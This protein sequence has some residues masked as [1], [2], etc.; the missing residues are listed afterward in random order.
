MK[1]IINVDFQ[2]T[3]NSGL[4]CVAN[5]TNDLYLILTPALI[6]K[7]NY[8][9]EV[10]DVN[11]QVH[12]SNILELNA[13][14]QIE[15]KVDGSYFNG[16]GVMKIRLLS[17]E[18]NSYY[19]VFNC[20][21]FTNEDLT[22]KYINGEYNFSIKSSSSGMLIDLIY[23]IGTVITNSNA[24]FN[25]NTLYKG[26]TW[27]RVKGKVIVGV[28]ENDSDFNSVNKSGGNKSF[29]NA[30]SHTVN[31]HSHSINHTHTVNSHKHS[32]QGHTLTVNEMPSHGH[33]YDNYYN[34]QTNGSGGGKYNVQLVW[35]YRSNSN[36]SVGAT[37]GS[38]PHYHGD[39]GYS[40]PSTSGA[41]TSNSG[42]ASPDT[43]SSQGT[44]SLLQPYITKYVWERIA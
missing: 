16:A 43:S 14:N 19:I 28:D 35:S 23:P 27:V 30:H 37:G 41:S 6:Q 3:I 26:T 9:V 32:T 24:S 4:Y 8:R 42:N 33:A 18:S 7:S 17:N 5:N 34:G 36:T 25:P 21:K 22:L 15:Y 39:T 12:T 1:N 13:N 40:S 31:S 2:N 10:T 29:N 11:K 20:I 38:Q 44:Q